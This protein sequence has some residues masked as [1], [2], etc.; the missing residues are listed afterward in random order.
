[1]CHIVAQGISFQKILNQYSE[2]WNLNRPISGVNLN[3]VQKSWLLSPER[4]AVCSLRHDQL[5]LPEK[6]PHHSKKL[7]NWRR[8]PCGLF[9]V[10]Q[11][12]ACVSDRQYWTFLHKTMESIPCKTV[13]EK[14]DLF[15]SRHNM[16][17][18]ICTHIQ[19]WI[20]G[21]SNLNIGI[22]KFEY[23][24]IQIWI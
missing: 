12:H 5:S 1:M 9:W 3:D 2:F 7:Q 20:S 14:S 10:R 21:Y 6:I 4:C 22:F 11:R 24:D 17:T 13:S 18:K 19:I 15:G 8:A 16:L 23:W